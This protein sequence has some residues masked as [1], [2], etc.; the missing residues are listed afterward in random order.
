MNEMMDDLIIKICK[1]DPLFSKEYFKIIDTYLSSS[2]KT[3]LYALLSFFAF[4]LNAIKA[5]NTV[6][7]LATAPG[8]FII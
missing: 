5:Q 3:L 4:Y 1:V 6:P 7:F 2:I 8:P